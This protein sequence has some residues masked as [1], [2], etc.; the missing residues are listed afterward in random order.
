M[1]DLLRIWGSESL[2]QLFPPGHQL[3]IEIEPGSHFLT[4]S[5]WEEEFR[6]KES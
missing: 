6:E 5:A 1:T 4:E 2:D 3:V